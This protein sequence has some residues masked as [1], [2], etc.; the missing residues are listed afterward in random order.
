[1]FRIHHGLKTRWNRDHL[2]E[3]RA[4]VCL[5]LKH[6]LKK[7]VHPSPFHPEIK[8]LVYRAG[9]LTSVLLFVCMGEGIFVALQRGNDCRIPLNYASCRVS[10]KMKT[11]D[12]VC[13]DMS[14]FYFFL[15]L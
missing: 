6:E 8:P 3:L 5:E 15:F 7:T 1:M 12:D 14:C 9:V 10:G 13:V 2:P 4:Q 11:Y